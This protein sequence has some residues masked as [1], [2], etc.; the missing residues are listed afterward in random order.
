LGRFTLALNSEF[1]SCRTELIDCRI[2]VSN[3]LSVQYCGND[4]T[5]VESGE[6]MSMGLY[7]IV[8]LRGQIARDCGQRHDNNTTFGSEGRL[9]FRQGA[10]RFFGIGALMSCIKLGALML[11]HLGEALQRHFL[12]LLEMRQSS[13]LIK[14]PSLRSPSRG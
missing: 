11:E 6:Q 13:K 7:A 9:A 2:F 8:K 3:F 4:L 14:F 10:R 5:R 12:K 1:A